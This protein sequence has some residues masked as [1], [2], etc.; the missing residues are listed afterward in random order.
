[1]KNNENISIPFDF[2]ENKK[3]MQLQKQ[4]EIK[5]VNRKKRRETILFYFVLGFIVVV[6][7]LLIMSTANAQNK[8]ISNCLDGGHAISRCYRQNV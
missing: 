5:I 6:T 4:E 1:M 7:F 8:A 3:R 2:K